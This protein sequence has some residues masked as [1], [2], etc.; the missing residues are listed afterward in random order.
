[1]FMSD[2]TRRELTDKATNLLSGWD[3]PEAGD[4]LAP[5]LRLFHHSRSQK[6]SAAH[7]IAKSWGQ[8]C[9]VLFE[10]YFEWIFKIQMEKARLINEYMEN[11]GG[12]EQDRNEAN[13]AYN[14]DGSIPPSATGSVPAS[15]S[16]SEEP[17][18]NSDAT[19]S[20]MPVSHHESIFAPLLKQSADHY[21][22]VLYLFDK[23]ITALG[24]VQP[25][26]EDVQE[27]LLVPEGTKGK[28]RLSF[29]REP[30]AKSSKLE[31]GR[32]SRAYPSA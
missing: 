6:R 14:L 21:D 9:R 18:E 11:Q 15:P 27:I 17:E 10:D 12:E 29:A 8:V 25:E 26:P 1:M 24:G 5:K 31:G 32:S 28:R 30:P 22:N 20:G 2:G 19:P 3:K 13:Q 4:A 7:Q 23:A 16:A